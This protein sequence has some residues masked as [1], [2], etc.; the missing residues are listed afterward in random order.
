MDKINSKNINQSVR[1]LRLLLIEDDP[2][3]I[4]LISDWL[5]SDVR[6]V[7]ASS[8]GR[9]IGLLKTIK[10]NEESPYA[11][12]LLDHD[13]HQQIVTEVDR[14]LSGSNVLQFII[15]YLP[16]DT[17]VLIHSMNFRRADDLLKKLRAAKF[18]VTRIPFSVLN[19]EN[20]GEWLNDVR[21]MWEDR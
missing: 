9:A 20:L 6:L 7:V 2:D 4:K 8:A 16:S 5:P 15:Q 1:V 14:L 11:G 3:R 10:R 13:L 17:P 12:L 18:D 19:K 21:D